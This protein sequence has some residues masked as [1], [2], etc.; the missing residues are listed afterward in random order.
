MTETATPLEIAWTV[1]MVIGLA[2]SIANVAY[3]Y[4]RLR[5][6]RRSG[7]N[8]LLLI[9][10][11]GTLFTQCVIAVVFACLLGIGI[12]ALVTPPPA[13]PTTPAQFIS[14]GLLITAAICLEWLTI[15]ERLRPRQ[16]RQQADHEAVRDEVGRHPQQ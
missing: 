4:C 16:L 2:T 7:M 12:V 8:G 6:L 11:K 14:G 5:E 15:A 1:A 3:A 13:G 10:R 9:M